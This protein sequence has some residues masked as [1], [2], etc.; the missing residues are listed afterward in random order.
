MKRIGFIYW[1]TGFCV[2]CSCNSK[3]ENDAQQSAIFEDRDSIA[4]T[5]AEIMV[6]ELAAEDI[7]IEKEL[8]YDKHTLKGYNTLLSMGKDKRKV[9]FVGKYPAETITMVYPSEL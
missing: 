8:L 6:K 4:E 9:S 7:K 3:A 1:L 5:P 2:L